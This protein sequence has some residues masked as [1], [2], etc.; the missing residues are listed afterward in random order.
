MPSAALAKVPIASSVV[1]LAGA[2]LAVVPE[3]GLFAYDRSAILAGQ[4][5]RLWTG[6]GVHFSIQ[7]F[8]M[9]ISALAL[10]GLLAEREFGVRLT[11]LVLWLG[12]PAISLGL[13]LLVPDLF[14]YRGASALAVLLAWFVG[15]ALW[16]RLSKLRL[17]LAVLGLVWTVKTLIEAAGWVSD[18]ANLP[19]DVRVVWQAHGLGAVIGWAC[20]RFQLNRQAT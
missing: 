12:M 4:I 2:V 16:F 15:S 5:W 19:A 11:A 3:T 1:V 14:E 13:L 10:V 8:F 7:Q 9:D 20:A 18:V 17:G 6:H